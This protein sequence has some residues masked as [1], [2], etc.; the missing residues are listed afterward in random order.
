VAMVAEPM[1]LPYSEIMSKHM[2]G[3]GTRKRLVI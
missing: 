2:S 1:R 3:V